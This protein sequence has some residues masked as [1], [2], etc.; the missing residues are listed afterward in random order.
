MFTQATKKKQKK[1][2][3]AMPGNPQPDKSPPEQESTTPKES[4]KTEEQDVGKT[5]TDTSKKRGS[6]TG[7]SAELSCEEMWKLLGD[8][9]YGEMTPHEPAPRSPNK[10]LKV[11]KTNYGEKPDVAQS[12]KD[13]TKME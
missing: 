12:S 5:I 9:G 2:E 10:M 7:E 6:D 13:N 4:T 11:E 1:S 3:F 8:F